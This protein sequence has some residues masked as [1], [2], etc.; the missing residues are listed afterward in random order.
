VIKNIQ[1][2]R[3]GG[4]M[5]ILIVYDIDVGRVNTV[6]KFLKRYLN[7]RQNSVFEGEVSRPQLEEIREGLKEIIEKDVDSVMIYK[8]PSKRNFELEVVG[9]EKSPIERIL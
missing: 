8:L 9:I 3:C 4:K 6:N 1:V 7:W 2:L 5:Y